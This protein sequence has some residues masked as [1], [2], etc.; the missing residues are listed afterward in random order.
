MTDPTSADLALTSRSRERRLPPSMVAIGVGFV[1]LFILL[2]LATIV[3]VM[4]D[5][6]PEPPTLA[7]FPLPEGVEIVDSMATCTDSACDGVGVVIIGSAG[8]GVAGRV[9]QYWRDMGWG[10]LP[11]TDEGTMCFSDEDLRISLSVWAD[12]DPLQ[13]PKLWESVT[14]KGLDPGRLVYVHFYRCGSIF[15]C[16]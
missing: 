8:E 13:V 7:A 1:G 16:E 9:A 5:D 4:N 15:P 12:V 14:N 10:S 2:V 3:A 11:C 6:T